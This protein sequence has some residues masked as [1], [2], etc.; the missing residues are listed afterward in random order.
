MLTNLAAD[1]MD[2]A[3]PPMVEVTATMTNLEETMMDRA[4]DHL[5]EEI[6]IRTG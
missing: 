2:M 6:Q 5:A 3:R 4:G 1:V